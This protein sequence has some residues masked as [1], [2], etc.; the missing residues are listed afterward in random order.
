MMEKELIPL[1]I[2]LLNMKIKFIP[3]LIILFWTSFCF[4][5]NIYILGNVKQDDAL[6][7]KFLISAIY[8]NYS[9]K[10]ISLFDNL[11]LFYTYKRNNVD[12]NIISDSILD[13]ALKNLMQLHS[14]NLRATFSEEEINEKKDKIEL[15]N[16]YD[17]KVKIYS[18]NGKNYPPTDFND[19]SSM[20]NYLS[21]PEN[22]DEKFVVLLV[23]TK[24]KPTIRIISPKGNETVTSKKIEGTSNG[25]DS[26]SKVFVRLNDG[27]WQKANGTIEWEIDLDLPK[28]NSL[29]EA[30]AIDNRNDTSLTDTVVDILFKEKIPPT[31]NY[32]YPNNSQNVALKCIKAGQYCYHFKIS[33]DSTINIR[34]LTIVLEDSNKEKISS[35]PLSELPGDAIIKMPSFNEYCFFTNYSITGSPNVCSINI[36]DDY[37]YH[38]EYSGIDTVILP[39]RIK[40]HF[41]SFNNE[42]NQ[43]EPCNCE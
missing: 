2:N 15:I 7:I 4:S 42:T 41:A 37:F 38:L 14:G 8:S 35:L 26:V 12:D 27:M 13:N 30:I 39:E 17:K 36:D 20:V 24:D 33:V 34:N 19:F 16:K 11:N 28:V 31:V 1:V 40:V 3:L 5:Q 23:F 9:P 43:Y 10:K 6:K 21:D 22:K 18:K 25:A 29:I 32:I